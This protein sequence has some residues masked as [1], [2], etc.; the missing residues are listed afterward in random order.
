MDARSDPETDVETDSGEILIGCLRRAVRQAR[1]ELLRAQAHAHGL[2]L[3][4]ASWLLHRLA[5]GMLCLAHQVQ[6]L[7]DGVRGT[8][9]HLEGDRLHP[10]AG[11]VFNRGEQHLPPPFRDLGDALA[12][13]DDAAAALDRVS[14]PGPARAGDGAVRP[15]RLPA[16]VVIARE[17]DERRYLRHVFLW[18][19]V[20]PNTLFHATMIHAL[21]RHL[22][23]PLGKDDFLG[24]LAAPARR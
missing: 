23:V 16:M 12:A 13:L 14:P 19:V 6:V 1:H 2:G 22:G 4:P 18:D 9:A 21:L 24:P 10:A 5:P 17:G 7:C 8:V 20:L 11:W 3:A 15:D